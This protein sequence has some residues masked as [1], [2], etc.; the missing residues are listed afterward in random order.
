MLKSI[1]LSIE[2]RI[3]MKKKNGWIL[4]I[5]LLA[6]IV[7]GGFMSELTKDVSWLRWLSYG[8]S[9]GLEE[10]VTL[11]LS[12]ITISLGLQIKITIAGIIGMMI[13]IFLY[14]KL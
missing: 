2:G 8:S 11:N 13:G 10:P 6:G 1:I 3:Y 14:K 5:I 12:V 7:V 9:F 4:L